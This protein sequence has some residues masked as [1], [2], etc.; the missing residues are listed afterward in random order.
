MR[1]KNTSYSGATGAWLISPFCRSFLKLGYL[2]QTALTMC[3]CWTTP[4][5]A[6]WR[7]PPSTLAPPWPT[8][9]SSDETLPRTWQQFLFRPW[10]TGWGGLT[11]S[12]PSTTL[13]R[14]TQSVPTMDSLNCSLRAYA[15]QFFAYFEQRRMNLW[16]PSSACPVWLLTLSPTNLGHCSF[17]MPAIGWCGF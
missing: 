16:K 15:F 11:H 3:R 9:R 13:I 12:R 14:W 6:R 1:H 17:C 4:S 2:S 5:G 7:S 10:Q 8:S